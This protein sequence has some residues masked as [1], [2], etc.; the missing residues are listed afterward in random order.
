MNKTYVKLINGILQ[1]CH[2]P[3]NVSNPSNEI[4]EEFA[5]AN[6]YKELVQV[7][8]PGRFY[9]KSYT[10]DD[11]TVTE[12]WTAQ[13]LDFVRER[14]MEAIQTRLTQGLSE[15]A[16]IDC[17][18]FENGIVYDNDALVNAIGLEVGD[19]YIDAKDEVH[20]L[21]AEDIT[22]IKAALKGHRMTLYTLATTT[23]AEVNQAQ[24]VDDI[25]AILNRENLYC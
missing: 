15:R 1:Y 24:T 8:R 2:G 19:M 11:E 23:R 12:V 22:N 20:Q 4:I 7:D 10:E 16:T 18:G 3:K 13:N 6:G 5:K 14:A 21:T 9:D 17:E 25:E